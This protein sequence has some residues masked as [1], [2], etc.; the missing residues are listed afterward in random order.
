MFNCSPI[1]P[2]VLSILLAIIFVRDSLIRKKFLKIRTTISFVII[3][4]MAL[5]AVFYNDLTSDSNFSNIINVFN[6]AASILLGFVF[7]FNGFINFEQNELNNNILRSFDDN[8]YY[9]YINKKGKVFGI[10]KIL[11][12]AFGLEDSLIGQNIKSL[13]DNYITINKINGEKADN[14]S[15]LNYLKLEIEDTNELEIEFYLLDCSLKTLKL[16]ETPIYYKDKYFARLYVGKNTTIILNNENPID[17][18]SNDRLSIIIDEIP[19]G[20]MIKNLKEKK[21]WI[22]DYILEKLNLNNNNLNIDEYN[23]LINSD[24]LANYQEVLKRIGPNNNQFRE[25]YRISNG[26]KMIYLEEKGKIL[27]DGNKPVEIISYVQVGP[28][29]NFIHTNTILDK[30]SNENECLG[31]IN[32]L[33]LNKVNYE[34][35]YFKLINIPQINE[36]FDRIFGT[37]AMEEYVKTFNKVFADEKGMFRIT[38]LEFVFIISDIRKME[39]FKKTIQKGKIFNASLQYGAN[40]CVLDVKMGISFSNEAIRPKDIYLN[41]KNALKKAE[42]RDIP[43]LFYK[44]I[45]K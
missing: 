10:S 44:D 15:F 43:Y 25:F 2:L 26:S 9:L 27:F 19:D 23:K 8:I 42:E 3:F 21:V 36:E 38:G 28:T 45:N 39:V 20:L 41:A 13:F 30:L 6:L 16:I 14:L 34:V 1:V 5:L 33:A 35:V 22:N 29:N 11:E 37:L 18:L 4:V 24:D 17:S 31:Y 7:I 12:Q 32:E 40:S